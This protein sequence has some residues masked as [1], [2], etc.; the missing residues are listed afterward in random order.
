MTELSKEEFQA[1]FEPRGVIVAGASSHPAKFGFTALHNILAHGYEGRVF[2]TN[3]EGEEILGVKT[4]RDV[5]NL[6]DGQAD[7]VFVCTP[8]AAC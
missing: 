3:R 7:L 2:A 6:P 4:A 8:S 5:D 1:L